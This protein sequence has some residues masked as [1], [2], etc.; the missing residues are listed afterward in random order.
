MVLLGLLGAF[1]S[2]SAA[3]GPD[4]AVRAYAREQLLVEARRAL[5]GGDGASVTQLDAQ[6]DQLSDDRDALAAR[7]R[8]APP[9]AAGDEPEW[10]RLADLVER[11]AAL[12][13]GPATASRGGES[14][15]GGAIADALW[16][17]RWLRGQET[18]SILVRARG[19]GGEPVM[20][21]Y[22]PETPRTG[23]AAAEPPPD[24]VPPPTGLA[25]VEELIAKEGTLLGKTFEASPCRPFLALKPVAEAE[26]AVGRGVIKTLISPDAWTWNEPLLRLRQGR[27]KERVE[28]WGKEAPGLALVDEA[29]VREK[30]RRV[31]QR[32]EEVEADEGRRKEVVRNLDE[33]VGAASSLRAANAELAAQIE[34]A[35]AALP[36][37]PEKPAG[38]E[39]PPLPVGLRVLEAREALGSLQ[40]RL[41]YLAALWLEERLRLVDEGLKLARRELAAAEAAHRRFADEM[42]R[43]RSERLLDRLTYQRLRLEQDLERARASTLAAPARDAFV[44]AHEAT[45]RANAAVLDL[46]RLRRPTRPSSEAAPASAPAAPPSPAAAPSSAPAPASPRDGDDLAPFRAPT[47]DALD[48]A[49]V[50]AAAEHVGA[51]DAALVAAHHD[52][53]VRRLE[54]V[55]SQRERLAGAET[56]ERRGAAS[57]A[58]AVEATDAFA[59]AA[60]RGAWR[61]VDLRKDLEA[62]RDDLRDAAAQVAGERARAEGDLAALAAYRA[63]LLDQGPRS[64]AIRENPQV[65]AEAMGR[66]ARE[67]LA[68]L[69]SAGRWLAFRGDD[70][71]GTFLARRPWRAAALVV[72]AVGFAVLIRR[73]RR[74]LDRT[75]AAWSGLRTTPGGAGVAIEERIARARRDLATVVVNR[76]QDALVDAASAAPAAP[77]VAPPPPLPTAATA[78]S[79]GGSAGAPASSPPSGTAPS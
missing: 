44:A 54:R 25:V 78:P 22:P 41:V 18:C 39:A 2:A 62:L 38:G 74:A 26:A 35:R 68:W 24:A 57:I 70:H 58:E 7:A 69:E 16:L 8:P 67:A 40:M 71:L 51:F 55:R 21:T 4:E 15:A 29:T 77:P 75:L 34:E 9:A 60:P 23:E 63:L 5:G 33:L 59:R 66:G 65:G 20:R 73:T 61:A 31:A 52:A 43:V 13:T 1:V 19:P 50:K 11:R 72:L 79:V 47:A 27:S 56:L 42:Q 49:Y 46:V 53:A 6:L 14:A 45:L 36:P 76:A 3:D 10:A 32:R 30:A 28:A 64:F 12:L 37:A 48:G 17:L